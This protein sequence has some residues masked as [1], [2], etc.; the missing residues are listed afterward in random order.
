M[1][2]S[3]KNLLTVANDQRSHE[4]Q[5]NSRSDYFDCNVCF[6]SFEL[7]FEL[8]IHKKK[9]N[10]TR[11]ALNLDT[12]DYV[13]DLIEFEDNVIKAKTESDREYNVERE[14]RNP[15]EEVGN[16]IVP[17]HPD[18]VTNL[19]KCPLCQSKWTLFQQ[20]QDHISQYHNISIETQSKFGIEIEEIHV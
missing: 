5:T 13:N 16:L 11:N 9:H 2:Y 4:D 14:S 8:A 15:D 17:A 20:T 12:D 3:H 7:E 19:Y 18:A 10:G 6:Q 1:N